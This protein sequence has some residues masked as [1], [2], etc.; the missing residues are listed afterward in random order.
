MNEAN[1]T[2]AH[3]CLQGAEG[4][5]LSFPEILT[6]LAEAGFESYAIDYRRQT[7][8]YYQ[9]DGNSVEFKTHASESSVA[10]AFNAE[11]L[12][13]AIREAQTQAPGYTYRGFCVK[14]MAAG[15]AG[16]LVSLSGQRVLYHG[17]TG[18]THVE[19]FPGQPRLST[20][21]HVRGI[22]E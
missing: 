6:R 21:E 9:P 19:H 10:A 18:E 7:A 13:A 17:R 11:A 4:N 20:F 2:T 1:K 14:A 22:P 16:Y 3:E 15:C 5:R 8:I 12:V